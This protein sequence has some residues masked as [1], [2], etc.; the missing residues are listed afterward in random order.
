MNADSRTLKSRGVF[1][2][3]AK[4]G[5]GRLTKAYLAELQHIFENPFELECRLEKYDQSNRIRSSWTVPSEISR[6]VPDADAHQ[7]TSS[8]VKDL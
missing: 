7:S 3:R 8:R 1:V 6:V 5:R 2:E 4:G